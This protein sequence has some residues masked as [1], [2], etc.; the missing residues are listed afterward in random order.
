MKKTKKV[1]SFVLALSMLCTMF[2]TSMFV[3]AADDSVSVVYTGDRDLKAENWTIEYKTSNTSFDNRQDY[4]ALNATAG[5]SKTPA[6]VVNYASPAETNRYIKITNS[7]G[8]ALPVESTCRLS[9]SIKS[10]KLNGFKVSLNGND[11]TDFIQG[12]TDASGFTNYYK[13][14]TVSAKNCSDLSF[15][16]SDA[17]NCVI[18]NVSLK[19]VENGETTG[20][21]LITNGDFAKCGI[22]YNSANNKYVSWTAYANGQQ[23]TQ[24]WVS[25]FSKGTN[26]THIVNGTTLAHSG[27][28]AFYIKYTDGAEANKFNKLW[29][30]NSATVSKG[31]YIVE[32]WA[33][34]AGEVK[35]FQ[36][37]IGNSL[38]EGY[39]N[40]WNDW[41]A[42]ET[43]ENGWVKYRAV[44]E[45]TKLEGSYR[46]IMVFDRTFEGAID[47]IVIAKDENNNGIIDANETNLVTDGGFENIF[48][49][50]A[51][52][53][54]QEYKFAKWP[55]SKDLWTGQ[56]SDY[57]TYGGVEYGSYYHSKTLRD[58][59][60]YLE[61]S[62]DAYE[63]NYSLHFVKD[64]ATERNSYVRFFKKDT[65]PAGT[66]TVDFYAKGYC[67]STINAVFNWNRAE[68]ISGGAPDVN[69]WRHYS[70]T[71]K[72]DTQYNY[73]GLQLNDK[74]AA[75]LYIDNF[76]VKDSNGNE[77]ITV[78]ETW[79]GDFE[80]ASLVPGNNRTIGHLMAASAVEG[81]GLNVSWTN[82]K[83][84]MIEDITVKV[85]GKL[86]RNSEV[87]LTNGAFNEMFIGGLENGTEYDI[88]VVAV[89]NGEEVKATAKGTPDGKGQQYVQ[90]GWNVNR[91]WITNEV[92][93]TKYPNRSNFT[94]S[95]DSE[96]SVSGNSM[97]M[98]FNDNHLNNYYPNI[99]QSVKV[100]IKD[101]HV[102]TVKSKN[103]GLTS[104]YVI[105]NYSYADED[106]T[107][108]KTWTPVNLTGEADE[109]GWTVSNIVLDNDLKG[110]T[111]EVALKCTCGTNHTFYDEN[112]DKE[113]N[114]TLYFACDTGFGTLWLDDIGLYISE[115]GEV[116]EGSENLLV[117]GN[118]D[119]TYTISTVFTNADGEVIDSITPGETVKVTAKITNYVYN[120]GLNAFVAVAL[121]K[122]GALDKIFKTEG[123]A[124]V[125]GNYPPDTFD[126]SFEIPE[127]AASADADVYSIKVMYWNGED[128]MQPYVTATELKIAE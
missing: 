59:T 75:D 60:T 19:K 120:D 121:Y 126:A 56:S 15:V 65:I 37:G 10:T 42:V 70:G 43:D 89:C 34:S 119:E 79:A 38:G 80:S 52:S 113:V 26:D 85:D 4:A 72:N 51:G 88:E 25:E 84:N 117:N 95:L 109:N 99:S 125:N 96:T 3:S 17:T 20:D 74:V 115:F 44:R 31:K 35:Y 24:S 68:A 45:N 14:Y 21:E 11:V 29:N 64:A 48:G 97:K 122:N 90:N 50:N 94:A 78:D 23:P 108:H 7:F 98:E 128:T 6:M 73:V 118:F 69:G 2:G 76:S 53:I 49:V 127:T 100:N 55:I 102:L 105:L 28:F 30:S 66:Y 92:G 33:K 41:K 54:K 116:E 77:L 9:Y 62:T 1:L 104:Y 81:G 5:V 39:L 107:Q 47:D 112:V 46:P 32:F 27:N 110:T 83:S 86:Y 57:S 22:D 111:N 71:I 18:D 12:E 58:K 40:V 93:G 13:D 82:P 101:E 63:G 106:G 36:L 114:L 91:F 124:D 8:Y 67:G 123:K 16:I 87:D 103:D 61:P